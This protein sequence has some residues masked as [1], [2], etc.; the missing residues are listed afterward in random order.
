MSADEFYDFMVWHRGLSQVN[1]GAGDRLHDC[2]ARNTLEAIMWHGF[3]KESDAYAAVEKFF[4]LSK[5]DRD[6]VILFVD[7]I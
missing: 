1:T 4:N 5:D 6:A 2:R 3:S 7:S